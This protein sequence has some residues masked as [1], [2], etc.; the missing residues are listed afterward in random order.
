MPALAVKVT[1]GSKRNQIIGF[2]NGVLRVKIAAK[3][4]DGKANDALVEYMAESLGIRPSNVSIIR[5]LKSRDKVLQ[6]LGLTQAQVDRL[7]LQLCA[8]A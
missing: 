5:G 7:L 2:A 3:A 6:I 8:S 1:P 4:L